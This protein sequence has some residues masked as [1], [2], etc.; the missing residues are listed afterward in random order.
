MLSDDH[1]MWAML[2]A[3]KSLEYFP[4]YAVPQYYRNVFVFINE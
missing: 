1:A 3:I 4:G 2:G